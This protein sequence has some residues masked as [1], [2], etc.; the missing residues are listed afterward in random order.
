MMSESK[1]VLGVLYDYRHY[2]A[3]LAALQGAERSAMMAPGSFTSAGGG[4]HA[5][6]RG[7]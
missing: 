1:I 2:S 5:P 6:R 4:G 3:L 7:R